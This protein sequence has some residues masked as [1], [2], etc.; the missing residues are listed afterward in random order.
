MQPRRAAARGVWTG[1]RSRLGLS[2][3]RVQEGFGEWRPSPQWL[4]LPEQRRRA[5][6]YVDPDCAVEITASNLCATLG[7]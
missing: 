2:G 1:A 3:C 5:A 4:G 7:W 6:D